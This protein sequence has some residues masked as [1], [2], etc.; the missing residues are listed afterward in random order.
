MWSL[1]H[2]HADSDGKLSSIQQ[3][4]QAR[5]QQQKRSS[6]S[7]PPTAV[8]SE[9]ATA[10]SSVPLVVIPEDDTP[11]VPQPVQNVSPSGIGFPDENE[12]VQMGANCL[13]RELCGHLN[14]KPCH[15]PFCVDCYSHN[16]LVLDGPSQSGALCPSKHHPCPVYRL[17]T[18]T[19]Q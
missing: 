16:F 1:R 6:L 17:D 11:W 14:L 13:F 5:E 19:H 3:R 15:T 9:T 10:Q 12:F 4:L 8:P 2:A 18:I 7:S